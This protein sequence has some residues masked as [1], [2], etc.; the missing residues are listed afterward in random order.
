MNILDRIVRTTR[1]SVETRKRIR[2]LDENVIPVRGIR[3]FADALTRTDGIALVAE[4]KRSSPSRGA[5]NED[6][7]PGFLAK[8]YEDAGAGAISLITEESYFSGRLRD[9]DEI[10][11]SSNLPVLRKDF[12]IDPYQLYESAQ[13]GF[14]AILLIVAILGRDEL[15]EFLGICGELGLDALIEVHSEPELATALS[16]SVK[17]IG[18]NNR[19]LRDFSVDLNTSVELARMIPAEIIKVSESGIKTRADVDLMR[20][21]GF[22]AV[23]VGE[24]IVASDDPGG[25][26]KRLL[27]KR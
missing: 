11:M 1:E 2:P 10:K 15:E 12:I 19:D 5:I 18:V 13:F 22:D 7:D 9:I 24:S 14:S 25:E 4:I 6:A 27:G 23:L 3:S 8:E 16:T 20:R 17:I 21:S 26:I